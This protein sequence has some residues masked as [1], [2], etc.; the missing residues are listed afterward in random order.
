M[1]YYEVW[2]RSSRYHGMEGL[3]Y[4][5][6]ERLNVGQIVQAEL[7]KELVLGVITKATA[8]PR[9]QTKPITRVYNLPL[10]PAPLLRLGQ[11]LQDYYPA[12]VGLI[13]QQLLPPH[14]TEKQLASPVP[15][16][17]SQPQLTT[18]PKLTGQ[19]QTA[20]ENMAKRDTYLLH[21]ITGSGKT[22]IYMELA[23]ETIT[24]GRSVI[25]LTPEISLTS[26]LAANF[27]AVFDGRVV[28]LHSAQTPAEHLR[29]WLQ[30]LRATEPVIVIGPRSALFSPLAT[31]G[32]IIVDEAHEAAY[33]QEQAPQYQ[34]GRVAAYLASITPARLILG[35]ATPS[36]SDYYLAE[37]KQRPIISLTKLA[38]PELAA[39]A[40]PLIIDMK[41]RS[42]FGRSPLV[43]QPLM[44][45]IETAL[46]NGEQSLLY[47]NR[48]GTARLV[49]CEHCGWQAACPH[50]DIP[51]TYHGDQHRLR[52]HSC[53]Y[54]ASSPVSCPDCGQA[55]VLFRTAGTK[56]VVDEIERLFP[57]ARLAR[58][59]TD[60]SRAE[61]F[62]QHYETVRDGNVDI[63]IGTQLLAKG[64]DLPRLSVL[65]V[66]LA[67]TSLYLPDF[68]AQERTY[69]LLTQVLGRINRG[70]IAGQ[71]IIQTYHPEHPVLRDAI[72]ANYADFYKRELAER[73]QFRFPPFVYLLKLSVRRASIA[74]TEKAAEALKSELERGGYKIRIEGPAPSFYEKLQNKYQWQLVVKAVD[75]GELLKVIAALPSGWSYDLDPLDLL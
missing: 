36:V 66:L 4:S 75:R 50:C 68:S 29:A 25:M 73:Q 60:N 27:Q 41:D 12:P 3:T 38:K 43:S 42:Q 51:L 59:D 53:N 62:E 2:V 48:R 74:A 64:L 11:W 52:C 33:K 40:E 72:T 45:A 70:H 30:I 24:S 15:L 1:F 18:L 65:G 49:M 26:Q 57:E 9:F 8:K 20:V 35:S 46:K 21:G 47:L 37:Q 63:L 34:T 13:S 22:R 39:T 69:Q 58:F 7:Q 28:V 19:Q 14:F 67:D 71:A 16:T 56:A 23:A 6:T 32:L 44:Q 17:F 31:V 10:L 5:S 61:R 54:Q 55:S